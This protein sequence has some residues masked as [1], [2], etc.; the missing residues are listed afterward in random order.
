MNILN[1][2]L[3]LYEKIISPIIPFILL[4]GSIFFFIYL[5]FFPI[6]RASLIISSLFSKKGSCGVHP[7]KSLTLALA[8]TLGVGN[9]VGVALAIEAGGAGAV[10]WMCLSSLAVGILKYAETVLAMKTRILEDGKFVGGAM[11]YLKNPFSAVFAL[12]CILSTFTIGNLIQTEA[13]SS[14]FFFTADLPRISVGIA[15]AC[16]SYAVT[17]L[18]AVRIADFCSAAVPFMSILYGVACLAV[19]IPSA[20]TLLHTLV[21]VI[22]DAFD[23]RCISGGLLGSLG[24]RAIR[25]GCARGLVTNEAGCGSAPIAHASSSASSPAVQGCLGIFEVLADT[26]LCILTALTVLVSFPSG[27]ELSGIATVLYAFS[28]HLGSFSAYVLSIA[29]FL[30]ALASMIGW[31]YYGLVALR[32]INK[33]RLLQG[34]YHLTCALFAIIGSVCAPSFIWALSDLSL[35][36]MTVINVFALII[37]APII[38]SET[39]SFIC[40]SK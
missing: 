28:S 38:K 25:I 16:I 9:I 5:K 1:F 31:S 6:R 36:L 7:L 4:I 34:L 11:Y 12:L 39:K 20:P 10:F 19:I 40:S 22:G 24:A 2:I 3:L 8:G 17:S 26:V 27:S 32:Y 37:H 33:G 15:L 18:G 14:A 21:Y 30:F 29:L 35:G 23:F 13:V